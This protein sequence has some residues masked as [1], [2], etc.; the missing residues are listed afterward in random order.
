MVWFEMTSPKWDFG[1]VGE[2]AKKTF[3]G[4][5]VIEIPNQKEP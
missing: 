2:G 3:G 1:Q 5:F 4:F